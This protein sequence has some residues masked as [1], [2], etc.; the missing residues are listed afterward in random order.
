MPINYDSLRG[1]TRETYRRPN[2]QIPQLWLLFICHFLKSPC[3]ASV[4]TVPPAQ[5]SKTGLLVDY[6]LFTFIL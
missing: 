4:G 1:P 2:P 6:G 5:G 3:L